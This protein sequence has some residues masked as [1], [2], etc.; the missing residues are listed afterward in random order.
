VKASQ[1]PSGL[2]RGEAW[3]IARAADPT[4]ALWGSDGFHPG[5][6]GTFLAALVVYE[7]ITGHDARELP[8]RAF[9]GGVSF[10]LEA[11]TIRLLQRSAHEANEA[12]PA[13]PRISRGPR[14]SARAATC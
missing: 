7:R 14:P 3:R 9:A 5:G 4:L 1:W 12:S 8:A 2:N 10:P 11:A 13:R 6:T